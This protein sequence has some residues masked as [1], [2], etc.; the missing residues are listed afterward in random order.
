MKRFV[1]E[2]SLGKKEVKN[3]DIVGTSDT[4]EGINALFNKHL[5]GELHDRLTKIRIIIG[6][7][8]LTNDSK[9]AQYKRGMRDNGGYRIINGYFTNQRGEVYEYP[10][11]VIRSRQIFV[12]HKPEY[13]N[14]GNVVAMIPLE[15]SET[16][17]RIE[18]FLDYLMEY[19]KFRLGDNNSKDRKFDNRK[20]EKPHYYIR[21]TYNYEI[22]NKDEKIKRYNMQR[23]ES[24]SSGGGSS[25]SSGSS[26]NKDNNL[27]KE[28]IKKQKRLEKKRLRQ[29]AELK[30]Y[31]EALRKEQKRRQELERRM[32]KRRKKCKKD[33]KLLK[34]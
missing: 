16:E 28:Q 13:D 27:T 6:E 3:L 20:K 29:E 23:M 8:T 5:R 4:I 14:N 31:E 24:G 25:S 12:T 30:E 19:H 2:F 1:I 22:R 17:R 15:N 18:Q 33:N 26:S 10:Y 21:D 11:F 32:M 34:F 7:R 9:S